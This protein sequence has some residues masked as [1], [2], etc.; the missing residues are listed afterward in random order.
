M[1][2]ISFKDLC[3]HMEKFNYDHDNGFDLD[4]TLTG[5]I[6]FTE[7][8]FERPYSEE[9]RSYRVT[10]HNKYFQHGMLGNGL[11]G[12]CLDGSETGVRLDWYLH[13]WKID[14]CYLETYVDHESEGK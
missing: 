7:D 12:E 8:S 14:Y 6:V 2:K 5:V 9:S 4:A 3:A 13:E 11:R 10:N 1:I